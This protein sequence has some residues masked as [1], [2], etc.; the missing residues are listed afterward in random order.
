MDVLTSFV[1][2]YHEYDGHP[3]DEETVRAALSGLLANPQF[4]QIWLICD[5]EAPAGYLVLAYCYSIEFKGR[6]AFVDELFLVE[7]HR[8]KGWGEAALDFAAEAARGA[9]IRALHLEVLRANTRAQGFYR[10][11][12]YVD[13]DR[14]LLTK[15]LDS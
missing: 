9:G 7:D 2:A 12:G 8:G 6:D 1:R 11:L 5:G 13:H 3:F 4:G 15:W 14:Y 10:R